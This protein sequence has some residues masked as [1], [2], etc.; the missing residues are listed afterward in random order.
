MSFAGADGRKPVGGH[1][2]AHAST[3]RV[4]LRKGRGEERVAKIQDSPGMLV[5]GLRELPSDAKDT[6]QMLRKERQHMSSQKVV[7]MTLLAASEARPISLRR[8]NTIH[9]P[10]IDYNTRQT[11][12]FVLAILERE[13]GGTSGKDTC[14]DSICSRLLLRLFATILLIMLDELWMIDTDFTIF[15]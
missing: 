3:T 1:V 4:L 14:Y 5:L 6:T 8:H 2:L 9:T 12:L 15:A 10:S 11:W 13:R 7:L